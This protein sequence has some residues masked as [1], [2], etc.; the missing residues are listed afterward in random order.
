MNWLTLIV[1]NIGTTLAKDVRIT[2]DPPLTTTV[3]GLDLTKS[4]LLRDGIAVLPPGR[5]VETLFDLSHDRLEQKLPMRYQVTVSFLDYRNRQQESLP[6]TIDLTYVY[7]LEQLGEKTMHNL[8]DEVDKLRTELEKWRDSDRGLLV[9][10]RPTCVA[11]AMSRVGSTPLRVPIA[12]SRIHG[13]APD[14]PGQRAWHSFVN[15]GS[16]G[17]AA[18]LLAPRINRRRLRGRRFRARFSS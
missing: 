13:Y 8:V 17:D 4:A 14:S 5:R 1:E 15:R 11:R 2:F 7:D 9:V 12:A 16:G 3:K 10:R 18:R 6:Y